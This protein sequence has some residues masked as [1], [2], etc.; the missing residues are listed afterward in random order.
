[1]IRALFVSLRPSQWLKNIFVL[2][3]PI[4]GKRIFVA[5]DA[6]R[7]GKAFGLFCAVS[8]G[9]YLL[10]DVFDRE[11]DRKHPEK[12]NRPIAA[13]ELPVPVAIAVSLILL[14][15]GVLGGYLLEPAFGGLL[16]LYVV[17]QV[18]Y[19]YRLKHVILVDVFCIASG[20]VLRVM[21][22]AVVLTALPL[23][24]WIILTTIFLSLFLAL[25]KRRAEVVLLSEQGESHRK[26]LREYQPEFL[27]QIIAVTTASVVLC[28]SLYTLSERTV[29]E[30]GTRNLVFTVPF[31]IFGI[32]RYLF[33]VHLREGGASPVK[34]LMT[35]VPLLVNGMLWVGVA[36]GIIY[37]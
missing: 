29:E 35:D 21:S 32:F 11:R 30:F 26:T 23:S 6:I 33:L 8:S 19:S 25:C 13:G 15:G 3:A 28:Y 5:A 9:V 24:S 2:A 16:L 22:G 4:F 14:L 36:V 10:N 37:L 17:V 27:D 18:L 31:V 1:M 34:T 20:F 12:K 7:V